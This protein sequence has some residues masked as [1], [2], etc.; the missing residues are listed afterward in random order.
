M[1]QELEIDIQVIDIDDNANVV[2]NR[3]KLPDFLS[4]QTTANSKS[5]DSS[6][7]ENDSL[8]KLNKTGLPGNG[9]GRS[10][11]ARQA[12]RDKVKKDKINKPD[13]KPNKQKASSSNE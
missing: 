13:Q 1:A 3:I 7:K 12:A 8:K 5:E 2:A 10:E 9:H 11:E 4:T 6:N